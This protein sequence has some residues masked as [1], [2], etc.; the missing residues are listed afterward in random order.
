MTE[1]IGGSRSSKV[2]KVV[3]HVRVRPF[4]ED[5]AARFGRES[6]ID[7]FDPAKRV[8][9]VKKDYDK[10]TFVFDSLLPMDVT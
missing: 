7:M 2:E 1:R 6:S 9:T 5:E 3:V 10:K 4:S 8:I